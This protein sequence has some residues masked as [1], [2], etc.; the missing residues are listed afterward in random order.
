MI[1]LFC[2]NQYNISTY[3]YSS[4]LHD[5]I[6][7]TFEKTI[8]EY[9][10]AKYAVSLNSATNAIFL[11]MLNKNVTVSIPSIIP[12]VVANAIITSGNKIRFTDDIKWVGNSYILHDF[13][14]YKI[15]DSAQK[16]ERNQFITE[17]NNN[18]LMIFS[19][20]P[21]KPIGSCDGGMIVSNDEDQIQLFREL[22]LNGM[23]YSNNN[24]DR[25][26]KYPGFKFYMNSIQADIAY[27]NFQVYENKLI[28]L[29]RI[30]DIYNNEFGLNNNSYHLYRI[31]VDDN[32]R[33]I[34]YMKNRNIQCGIHYSALHENK[35]YHPHIDQHNDCPMSSIES[36]TTVSLPYHEKLTDLDLINIISGV[37]NYDKYSGI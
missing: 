19:F 16:I 29:K 17:C 6:V 5:R 37:K 13:I 8:A 36:Q 32:K 23:T 4:L 31:N 10:G 18:D 2:I 9:V 27:N 25:T 1:P 11:A 15:I 22:S 28:N 20:Y 34:K 33:F 3:N 12:P 21:T 35:I 26:I 14:D 30:R 7:T 24:W